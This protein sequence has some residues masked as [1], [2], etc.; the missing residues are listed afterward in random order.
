MRRARHLGLATSATSQ[1]RTRPGGTVQPLPSA[2]VI[3]PRTPAAT[4]PPLPAPRLG[5]TGE[6]GAISR[7]APNRWR[8]R[9]PDGGATSAG[10]PRRPPATSSSP[11]PSPPRRPPS[12]STCRLGGGLT[13]P[14]PL[15]RSA[16]E[17]F[18]HDSRSA[19]QRRGPT[20]ARGKWNPPR[21][22]RGSC[23]RFRRRASAPGPA[24]RR[25]DRFGPLDL[26]QRDVRSL[27]PSAIVVEWR[28]ERTSW[29][30]PLGV[31]STGVGGWAERACRPRGRSKSADGR[32]TVQVAIGSYE[33][34]WQVGSR[35]ATVS[36][37][38]RWR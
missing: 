12:S 5:R 31:S 25:A 23:R 11:R 6:G 7:A 1:E 8:S 19:S 14:P 36:G 35:V 37:L 26:P 29:R 16:S 2:L 10:I 22:T 27:R 33:Q 24:R 38:A 13:D 34:C 30:L 20:S 21:G 28:G 18:D 32:L 17:P 9:V 15:S 3:C 4:S